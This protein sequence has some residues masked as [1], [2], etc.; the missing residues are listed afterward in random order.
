MIVVPPGCSITCSITLSICLKKLL[1]LSGVCKWLAWSCWRSTGRTSILLPCVPVLW[2]GLG[3]F[4][5]AW[6]LPGPANMGNWIKASP[7]RRTRHVSPLVPSLLGTGHGT[8]SLASGLAASGPP[9]RGE[10]PLC[11]FTAGC[12]RARE[13][14]GLMPASFSFSSPPPGCFSWHGVSIS[15]PLLGSAQTPFG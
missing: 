3:A 1:H 5:R 6:G 11:V 9:S 12:T 13:Q 8:L 7:A 2:Q 15:L 14:P 4:W 10:A